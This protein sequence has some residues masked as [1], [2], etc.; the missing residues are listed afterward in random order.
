[1][2]RNNKRGVVIKRNRKY[3]NGMERSVRGFGLALGLA[4]VL[5]IPKSLAEGLGW[6][7][8][9]LFDEP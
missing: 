1:M 2:L 7:A 9:A 3:G 4:F 8:V 6:Q 5:L